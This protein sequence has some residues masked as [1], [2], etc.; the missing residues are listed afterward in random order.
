LQRLLWLIFV[1]LAAGA[2]WTVYSRTSASRHVQTVAGDGLGLSLTREGPLLKLM[3]DPSSKA[4]HAADEVIVEA[5]EE[6]SRIR[7]LVP[8][9]QWATGNVLYSTGSGDVALGMKVI[10]GGREAA[11]EWVRVIET[12]PAPRPTGQTVRAVEQEADRIAPLKRTRPPARAQVA[13]KRE[14]SP[15]LLRR[16]GGALARLWPFRS[17]EHRH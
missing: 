9:E 16:T 12:P 5:N 13:V 7:I 4:L 10:K 1:V 15:G 6:G 17:R 3:W 14:Q 8:P 11:Y 2:A